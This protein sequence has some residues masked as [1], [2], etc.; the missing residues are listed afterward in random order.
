MPR[1]LL[2]ENG[3]PPPVPRI[4]KEARPKLATDGGGG[5]YPAKKQATARAK[6]ARSAAGKVPAA[7]PT[8]AAPRRAASA[9]VADAILAAAHG[10]VT[11]P[12]P[13]PS[14]SLPHS[15]KQSAAGRA[16][17]AQSQASG[18]QPPDSSATAFSDGSWGMALPPERNGA[19]PLP[20][21][22]DLVRMPCN[23]W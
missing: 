17:A 19:Q 5:G 14:C 21:K 9:G 3:E 4:A 16:A 2:E 22:Q 23:I 15:A 8:R 10:T 12:E 7:T 18:S 1:K 20:A 13:S 11:E 6:A